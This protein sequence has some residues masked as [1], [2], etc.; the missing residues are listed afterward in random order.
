MVEDGRLGRPRGAQVV[1]H[2]DGVEQL[3]LRLAVELRGAR[4]SISRSP[5]W[6]CPSSRP[7]GGLPV[8][9]PGPELGGAADIVQEGRGQKQVAAQAGCSCAVS[10]QR[11]ATPTVCSSRPP[12]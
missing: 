4:S 5:R 2:G 3:G 10:R 11:V 12:A 9:R 7:S 6:T 8:G 1:V